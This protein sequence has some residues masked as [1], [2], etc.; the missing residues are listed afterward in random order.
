MKNGDTVLAHTQM[1]EGTNRMLNGVFRRFGIRT[2]TADFADSDSFDKHKKTAQIII[3]ESITNPT[4]A[5]LD[6]WKIGSRIHQKESMFVVDNTIATPQ[7]CRPLDEGADVVVHSLTKYISGHH[8]VI[9]GAI[10]TNDHRIFEALRDIQW[11]LGAILSPHDCF[12][13]ERGIQ[14]LQIRMSAHTKNA[15]RIAQFLRKHSQIERVSFPGISG[16]VAFWLKGG[17]KETIQTLMRLKHIKIAHSFGG[18]QTTVLHPISMMSWSSSRNE[19]KRQ[20]ITD[21]LVR[22]SIGIEPLEVLIHDLQIALT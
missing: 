16:L 6:I 7:F 5:P 4:L 2:T 22:M 10:M 19:L 17:K 3:C 14:T 1:Y 9:A 15:K 18:T 20:G 8:D 12:L 11:T 13:I 21:N